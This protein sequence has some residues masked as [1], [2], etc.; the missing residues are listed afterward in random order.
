MSS[1]QCPSTHR[2]RAT[3][4]PPLATGV[5]LSA[6]T[7]DL[8]WNMVVQNAVWSY[9]T[10]T[11]VS[12][13]RELSAGFAECVRQYRGKILSI[14]TLAGQVAANPT[15]AS[16]HALE[17]AQLPATASLMRE[18]TWRG[19]EHHPYDVVLG[20][21]VAWPSFEPNYTGPGVRVGNT[22]YGPRE[23]SLV[24]VQPPRKARL[25]VIPADVFRKSHER[26]LSVD[27]SA[28][29]AL[30]VVGARAFDQMHRHDDMDSITSLRLPGNPRN[31]VKI[32]AAAFRQSKLETLHLNGCT[33]LT[34]I[35]HS[36]FRMSQLTV[37]ELAGCASLLAIEY[38]AFYSSNLT[39]LTLNSCIALQVIEDGVFYMSALTTLHLSPCK[40]LRVIGYG[41]FFRSPLSSLELGGC[42]ALHN[43]EANAFAESNLHALD[44]SRC[45]AIEHIGYKAFYNS[46]LSVLNLTGCDKLRWI[47]DFA[48]YNAKLIT[49]DFPSSNSIKGIGHSA[50]YNS[51]LSTLHLTGCAE[52]TMIKANAFYNA[53]LTALNLSNCTKLV[54]IGERVFFKSPLTYLDL[55][56]A[57]PDRTISFHT[58]TFSSSTITGITDPGDFDPDSHIILLDSGIYTA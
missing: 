11:A 50:F 54:E 6:M 27:L 1:L 29:D 38:D 48:F 14:L 21:L 28:C 19:D 33:A 26:F 13:L 57:H 2:L 47:H 49:L 31:L 37:L 24:T 45:N 7:P 4:G 52:L 58:N 39:Q 35:G 56:V 30:E 12:Q 42:S 51:P 53:N 46:P 43:I 25:R 34:T 8:L 22:L 40:A 55:G 9:P 20:V 16:V 36:A 5:D 3:A 15:V 23:S 10:E 17:A 44:L 41:A 32:G 18:Y